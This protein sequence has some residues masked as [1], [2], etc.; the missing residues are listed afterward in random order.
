MMF[1]ATDVVGGYSAADEILKGL[2]ITADAGEI[3]AIVG[4]N[5]A[6]KSTFLKAVTGVLPELKGHIE[7][8]GTKLNGRRPRQIAQ[9]GV[10][11]VPQENNV[12]ATMT[13]RENLEMGGYIASDPAQRISEMFE[14]FPILAEKRGDAARTLSGGQRQILAMAIAMMVSPRLLLLDEPSAG[15]SPIAATQLFE[16]IREIAAQQVSV[17]LVEQNA[18]DALNMCDRAYILTAGQ[19]HVTGSGAHLAADP[20]IRRTFLGG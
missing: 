13:V 11:Y 14:R 8:Y 16:T 10:A 1:Q 5:G 2:T 18:M 17:L 20:D 15:L 19:N 7:L 12:F 3:V 9:M 6:G 4:P